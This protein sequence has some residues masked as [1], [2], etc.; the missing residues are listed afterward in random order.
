VKTPDNIE[1]ELE[2]EAKR[3]LKVVRSLADDIANRARSMVRTE[4]ARGGQRSHEKVVRQFVMRPFDYLKTTFVRVSMVALYR[5]YK[6]VRIKTLGEVLDLVNAEPD[7]DKII[8]KLRG[9]IVKTAESTNAT[10]VDEDDDI[11]FSFDDS[12]GD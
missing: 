10:E 6:A 12:T 5:R 4:I 1:S 11:T 7:R 2:V 9:L 8:D 3:H